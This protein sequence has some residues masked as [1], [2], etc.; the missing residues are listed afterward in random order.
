VDTR[1]ASNTRSGDRLGW[2]LGL[3]STAY[4]MVVLDSL[5]VVS[6]LPRMQHDL[7]ASVASLQWTVNSYGISFAAGI[8]TAAALGDRFGRRAV[9]HLGL[10]PFTVASAL[11][12]LAPNLTDLVAARTVQGLGARSSGAGEPGAYRGRQRAMPGGRSHQ[13]RAR[14]VYALVMAKGEHQA[15]QWRPAPAG[16][17]AARM[18]TAGDDRA[19]QRDIVG[20][21]PAEH[22]VRHRRIL[23]LEARHRVRRHE[24][25]W[26]TGSA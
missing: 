2:V 4:F 19:R 8:V 1:T 6:A 21:L 14:G 25:P 12:A 17:R 9:F 7:H 10:L 13:H 22:E 26:Y 11:C 5:V 24:H 3:T 15:R 20:H 18:R 16:R 23:D